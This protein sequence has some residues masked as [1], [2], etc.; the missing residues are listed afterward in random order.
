MP[1]PTDS[2]PV[3]RASGI[4]Q[5]LKGP[6]HSEGLVL[7]AVIL[8]RSCSGDHKDLLWQSG[9]PGM[10]SRWPIQIVER[11]R[12]MICP[13]HIKRAMTYWNIHR[14]SVQWAKKFMNKKIGR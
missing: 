12:S 1:Y 3:L 2:T 7:E 13:S 5:V 4:P 14:I 6:F 8:K 9:L 11:L 10:T